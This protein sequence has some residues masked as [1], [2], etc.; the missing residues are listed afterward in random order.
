MFELETDDET[1]I[2]LGGVIVRGRPFEEEFA[3]DM[4]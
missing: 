4:T 3:F 2:S 1:E